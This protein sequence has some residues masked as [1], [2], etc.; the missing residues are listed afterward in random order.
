[1]SLSASLGGQ[2][3]TNWLGLFWLG[4]KGEFVA[5]ATVWQDDFSELG[6]CL[7]VTFSESGWASSH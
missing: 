1:M 5:T 6:Y 4:L 3:V 7:D 2:T